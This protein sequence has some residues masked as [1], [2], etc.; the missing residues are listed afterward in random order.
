MSD[1]DTRTE[2][3]QVWLYARLARY[4]SIARPQDAPAGSEMAGLIADVEAAQARYAALGA[5]PD[6]NPDVLQDLRE[7]HANAVRLRDRAWQAIEQARLDLA[8]VIPVDDRTIAG[9]LGQ[10]GAVA[11]EAWAALAKLD[12]ATGGAR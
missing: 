2:K 11:G 7:R 8:R 9:G 10:Y 1:T 4:E 12:A 6:P 3:E 5:Q